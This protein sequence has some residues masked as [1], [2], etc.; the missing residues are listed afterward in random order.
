MTITITYGN[1][2]ACELALDDFTFVAANQE[3]H[4]GLADPG[5]SARQ[6]LASPQGFP[7]L[8]TATVPGDQVA[9]AIGS[10]VQQ[11]S[12][13]LS[14]AVA[15]MLDA[16]VEPGKI[17]I[18]SIG[19]LPNRED[20]NERLTEMGA[21]EVR[22]EEHDPVNEQASAMIGVNAQGEPLRLN[23]TLAEADFV[24][25]IAAAQLPSSRDETTEKF[26]G[27]FPEF[28]TEETS[29]RFR[30]ERANGSA[31]SRKR[32]SKEVDEAGWLL[33]VGMTMSVIPGM[34]GAVAAVL[35]G[36]PETVSRAAANSMREI[37]EPSVAGQGDLVIATVVG[38]HTDQTWENLARAIS[39]ALPL[40]APGGAIAICSELAEPPGGAFNRLLD[41]VDFGD[42]QGEL[43]QDEEDDAL[44]AMTLAK[45]LDSGPVYLR[46]R[47]PSDVVESLGMTPIEDDEELSRLVAGREH[48]I[49][50]EEAQRVMPRLLNRAE[51]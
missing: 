2:N 16:G 34:A 6:A 5:Q 36:D 28:S 7:A 43:T 19:A 39:A 26:A 9:I 13:I 17:T 3:R 15:A 4:P 18:V 51:L 33:G 40:T 30:T 10:G 12:K 25:P 50:I 23:R 46:S 1:S 35:A 24:L 48:C 49:V 8:G 22:F 27:L 41:A 31:K 38:D 20:L 42:V 11:S 32:L 29:V 47:L 44:S 14:G 37:W 45:A 21:G